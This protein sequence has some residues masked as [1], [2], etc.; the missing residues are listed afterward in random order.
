MG[1]GLG[2]G[3]GLGLGCGFRF[4]FGLDV[5]LTR[6]VQIL[7]VSAQVHL[8]LIDLAW[9]GLRPVVRGRV[10]ARVMVGVCGEL[11]D[12]AA[13]SRVKLLR[14]RERHAL[15]RLEPAEVF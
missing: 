1:F 7:V 4:G 6:L 13:S 12:G 14:A 3:L 10:T 9:V 15:V 5:A 2:L 11:A 8:P